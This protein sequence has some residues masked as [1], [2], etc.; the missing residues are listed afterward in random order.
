MRALASFGSIARSGI[1]A[2]LRHRLRSAVTVACVVAAVLPYV[3]GLGVSR[4]LLDQAEVSLREG[5][6]LTVTGLRFG[7]PAPLP[8]SAVDVVRALP[9]VTGASPRIVGEVFLGRERHAAVLVGVPPERLPPRTEVVEGR[10]FGAGASNEIVVGRALASR[11]GLSPGSVI[12]PFY[13]N[14]EGERN[15]TVVGVFRSGVAAWE[16]NVVLASFETASRVFAQRGLAT[17]ILVSCPPAYRE[18]VRRAILAL[19]TLGGTD[20][21][22]PVRPR[23]MTR[24]DA[25]SLLAGGILHREGVFGLHFLLA[26][27]VGIPL[28]LVTSGIGLSERRRETGLLKA[29][30]WQ[31]DEVLVRAAAESLLLATAGAALSVCLAWVWLGA[32]GGAG[33]R[34]VFLDGAGGAGID[35]PFRLAPVPVLLATIASF[36]VVGVGTLLS[37]WRTASAAPLE[38]MR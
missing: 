15:S 8:V 20:A 24:A 27:A 32:F 16:A 11:L 21:H 37:T 9:G 29:L 28:V 14:D 7:R 36:A 10:L 3:A 30:G 1:D 31:T 2:A 13:E 18:D 6:D 23:V 25:E 35:L 34:D 12:P 5:A 33:V 17:E 22:G 4:G 19:R 38:A 26:F